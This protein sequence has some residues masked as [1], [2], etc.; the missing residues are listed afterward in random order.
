MSMVVANGLTHRFGGELALDGVD[1]VLDT[2]EHMA[3]LGDNGA[4]KTT[5]LRILAT[6][7]RPTSGRLQI[8]GL[9]AFRERRRLRHYIGYV[10]HNP[11]LYPALSAAENLEFFCDLQDV[12]RSRVPEALEMLGL[13]SV[14]HRRASLLSRGMQ[15]RLAIARAILH[16]PRLLIFDEPDASLDADAAELLGLVMKDRTAVI[17]THDHALANR[18]CPRTLV[19]RHG[20]SL[21]TATHLRVVR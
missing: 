6:A 1:L 18:L 9:D 3:V 11:G 7:L 8:A 17:A 4:G 20:R 14:A 5:L 2:G 13:G 15:Q 16:E 21:G 12:S 19:L 10:A